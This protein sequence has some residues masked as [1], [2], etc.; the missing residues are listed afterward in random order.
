MYPK[1]ISRLIAAAALACALVSS[2]SAGLLHRTGGGG[3]SPFISQLKIGGGGW[4]TRCM[5]GTNGYSRCRTDTYGGF[6]KNPGTGIWSQFVVQSRMPAANFGFFPTSGTGQVMQGSGGIYALGQSPSGTTVYF[7]WGHRVFV[8]TNNGASYTLAGTVGTHDNDAN[9]I[10]RQEGPK[11]AVDPN[12]S[13][14]VLIGTDQDGL[15]ETFNG[16]NAGGATFT[17]ISPAIIPTA[18]AS[19][20][21][22]FPSYNIVFDPSSAHNCRAGAISTCGVYVFAYTESAGTPN[23]KVWKSTDGLASVTGTTGGPTIVEDF[24]ISPTGGAVWA[25]D[26]SNGASENGG[27]LWKYNG[28]SWAQVSGVNGHSIAINPTNSLKMAL[29]SASGALT[30]SADGGVTW[31]GY[32]TN[33]QTSPSIPWMTSAGFSAS[34]GYMANGNISY[35]PSLTDTLVQGGGLGPWRATTTGLTV[36]ST[37]AW[38]SDMV[39]TEQLV[40]MEGIAPNGVFVVGNEDKASFYLGSPNTYPSAGNNTYRSA[41]GLTVTYALDYYF[42]NTNF[43][44]QYNTPSSGGAGD[45]SGYSTDGGQNWHPYTKTGA[46]GSS[47][48]YVLVDGTAISNCSPNTNFP[49]FTVPDTTGLTSWSNGAGTVLRIVN[50]GNI[51]GG[52]WY[53]PITVLNATQFQLQGDLNCSNMRFTSN[54][55]YQLIVSTAPLIDYNGG[56]YVTNV[57]N[58]GSGGIRVT[59]T[60]CNGCAGE[61]NMICF[62]GIAG[63][64][65]NGCWEVHNVS[66]S[67]YDL[68]NSTFTGT[69]TVG[70]GV[71]TTQM[72]FGGYVAAGSTTNITE[73]P[74]NNNAP[75]C[76]TDLG[77]TWTK[78]TMG[79]GSTGV[80]TPARITNAVW[81]SGSP[82]AASF[83]GSIAG[84]VLTVT[85][86]PTGSPLVV[87]ATVFGTG[88]TSTTVITSLG[89]GT[90]GVGTYNVNNSQTV[91]SEAMTTTNGQITFTTDVATNIKVGEAFSAYA[92]NPSGFNF[93]GAGTN[94]TAIAGTT[95]TTVIG[96]RTDGGAISNPGAYVNNGVLFSPETGWGFAYYTF[97]HTGVADRAVA[98]TFYSYNYKRGVYKHVNCAAGTLVSNGGVAIDS[99]FANSGFASLMKSV[100]GTS[101][102][103]FTSGLNFSGSFPTGDFLR[104]STDGGVTWQ[105]IARIQSVAKM[106]CGA[107][108]PG[109]DYPTCYFN[110]WYDTTGSGNWVYGLWRTTGTAAQWASSGGTGTSLVWNNVISGN[111]SL[112]GYDLGSMDGVQSVV[113]NGTIWNMWAMGHGGS[114]WAYGQQN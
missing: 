3:S 32:L 16:T 10:W 78:L 33:T 101:H 2:S 34:T 84:T 54:D 7:V 74:S 19:V 42:G 47:N 21:G 91:S 40:T 30:Y 83:T 68:F 95:G 8:S 52:L 106:D 41:F 65:G 89:T 90:G 38:T 12:N 26:A 29:A 24:A 50:D 9:G 53:A 76:T 35:D 27:Q 48:G 61:R 62:T 36:G 97:R 46:F 45:N 59:V 75:Y 51:S 104:R 66:P 110:G 108:A 58:N 87:G 94:F 113:A 73:W 85:G 70:T 17:S 114:G 86:T 56:M 1:K 67:V 88:V 4:T 15:F 14:H 43:M 99:F 69:Y 80:V 25:T 98:N 111:N 71:G 44:V 96:V 11:M 23:G 60:D 5:T 6:E 57:A 28:T 92:V 18:I 22:G 63:S 72:P 13:D 81:S 77:Q 93:S 20:F 79:S 31:T 102:L 105:V 49:I 55:H 107:I 103:F 100:P 109:S 39:G 82:T 37:V 64:N 112:P